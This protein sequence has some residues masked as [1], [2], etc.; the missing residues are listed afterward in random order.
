MI[1]K[2]VRSVFVWAL[3]AV[4]FTSIS[5]RSNTDTDQNKPEADSAAAGMKIDTAS[6]TDRSALTVT[7]TNEDSLI[8][9]SVTQ[10]SIPDS[11]VLKVDHIFQRIHVV[12]KNVSSDSLVAS[13]N[14]PGKERNVRIN[15]IIMPDGSMDGPF[16]HEIHYRTRQKG[17]YTLIVGKDNMADGQVEGPVTVFVKLL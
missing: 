16:G 1:T 8:I 7:E 6:I 11:I 5:C 2:I 4:A 15:Q 10:G 12:V 13:L 3:L 14:A 9:A 17:T